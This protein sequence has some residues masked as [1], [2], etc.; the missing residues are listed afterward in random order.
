MFISHDWRVVASARQ[1]HLIVMR[2]GKGGGGG[3][4]FRKAVQVAEDRLHARRCF[5]AAF[6]AGSRTRWRLPAE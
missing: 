1:R 5:A 3:A 6:P 4:G 2:D